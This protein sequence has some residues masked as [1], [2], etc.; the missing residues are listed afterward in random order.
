MIVM[1]NDGKFEKVKVATNKEEEEKKKE[2]KKWIKKEE[3]WKK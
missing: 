3:K 2:D 1:E